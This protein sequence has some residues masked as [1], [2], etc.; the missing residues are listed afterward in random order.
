MVRDGA[1]FRGVLVEK[2][3]G[4][5]VTVKLATGEFRRIVWDSVVRI[6]GDVAARSK[7]YV[8]FHANDDGAE[9]EEFAASGDWVSL[10]RTP[11]EGWVT[12]G[13]ALRVGGPKVQPSDPF[14]VPLGREQL[15]VD[16]DAKARSK[17]IWGVVTAVGGG[18]LFL[19]GSSFLTV[20]AASNATVQD[21]N[22]MTRPLTDSE[23]R[24]FRTAG[25][26]MMGLGAAVG[27]TGLVLL[28]NSQT[29][30][31]VAKRS[32]PGRRRAAAG[33]P[34]LTLRGLEF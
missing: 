1:V 22:G 32:V 30:V 6:D 14:Q 13:Q 15:R 19:V 11:C 29:E 18:G 33:G 27:I 10:C 7:T 24:N 9:L 20:G 16:A 28:L 8:R 5:Y 4:Q 23:R 25:G 17:R 12:Q 21:S 2:V 34:R 31:Q 3:P 26:V